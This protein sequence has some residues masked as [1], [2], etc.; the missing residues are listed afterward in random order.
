MAVMRALRTVFWGDWR[1]SYCASGVEA[2]RLTMMLEFHSP[3]L[4]CSYSVADFRVASHACVG[5]VNVVL[6]G[7]VRR[8][9]R[10]LAGRMIYLTYL[11]GDFGQFRDRNGLDDEKCQ[12]RS[13]I[14]GRLMLVLLENRR[15]I[16][17]IAR[18]EVGVVPSAA[19]VLAQVW[20]MW[21]SLDIQIE[22]AT[23]R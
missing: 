5:F 12:C 11:V 17:A 4:V 2:W 20:Q 15:D 21:E 22:L 19:I 3:T 14:Q 13:C 1:V 6:L 7:G 10:G 23:S 16:G 18:T 9:W 8:G